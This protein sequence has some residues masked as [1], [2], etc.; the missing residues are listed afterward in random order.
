[1]TMNSSS[2]TNIAFFVPLLVALGVFAAIV[3]PGELDGARFAVAAVAL[4]AIA[5]GG[6]WLLSRLLR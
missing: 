5:P 3:L 1:M 6:A 4:L 2:R